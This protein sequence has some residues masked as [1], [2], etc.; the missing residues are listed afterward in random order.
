MRGFFGLCFECLGLCV[1][2]DGN[3]RFSVAL[4]LEF[5][6]TVHLGVQGVVFTGIYVLS[7]IVFCPALSDDDVPSDG[8]L[9]AEDLN[10]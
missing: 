10:T 9:S 1:R 3:I 4:L 6:R 8:R 2:H 5:Y 7:G